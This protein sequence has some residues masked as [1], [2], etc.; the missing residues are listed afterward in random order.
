MTF[1]DNLSRVFLVLGLAGEGKCVLWLAVG[2][3]GID[4]MCFFSMVNQKL[5]TDFVD[6]EPFICSPDETRE[7]PLHILNVVEL[8]SQRIIDIHHD[9]FP[10][11]FS[12]IE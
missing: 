9:Y 10:I 1:V 3:M 12:L 4:Q 6:P 7:M 8:G 5:H 11:C 2:C